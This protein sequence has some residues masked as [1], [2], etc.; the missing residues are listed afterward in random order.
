MRVIINKKL[1]RRMYVFII[2]LYNL[3]N[4]SLLVVLK[5]LHQPED[6]TAKNS[7]QICSIIS[8]LKYYALSRILSDMTLKYLCHLRL[9]RSWNEHFL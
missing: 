2:K 7:I 5:I 3:T 8:F 4:C 6:V 1:R 9:K